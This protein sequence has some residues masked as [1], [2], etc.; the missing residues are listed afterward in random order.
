[1]GRELDM[2][3]TNRLLPLLTRVIEDMLQLRDKLVTL[4]SM[5][6]LA[7]GGTSIAGA[8]LAATQ[9]QYVNRY[10]ADYGGDIDD[11]DEP[12][13][14]GRTISQIRQDEALGIDSRWGPSGRRQ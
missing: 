7:G 8:Q 13:Y 2:E 10:A 4:L 12:R 14:G 6:S 5:L 1:M 11:D 3:T 9:Q